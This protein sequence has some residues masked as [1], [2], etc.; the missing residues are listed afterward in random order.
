MQRRRHYDWLYV[1]EKSASIAER[2]R[3]FGSVAE[4][5]DELRPPAPLALA[6]WIGLSAS[7]CVID[8]AAGTGLITRHLETS[9]AR[10][11][12]VEPDVAML[13]VLQRQSPGVSALSA[14]AEQ[15]PLA[16]HSATVVVIINAW[17]WVH[18]HDAFADFARVLANDGQ[19]VVGWNGADQ[20]V[21]WVREIFA[22][23]RST[24]NSGAQRHDARG[25]D[26]TLTNEFTTPR[27]ATLEWTW[28]RTPDQLTRLFLTY[29]GVITLDDARRQHVIDEVQRRIDERFAGVDLIELP[30]STRL[31]GARRIPRATNT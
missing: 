20:R 27:T 9:G 29:S 28:L 3:S 1:N 22:L 24:E 15:L 19:L 13:E 2:A 5:Y 11:I 4:L 31:W 21:D 30:M 8:V 16:D 26:T 17:H 7:D 18:Q 12:A 23:R 25:V 14:R 10:V 6:P